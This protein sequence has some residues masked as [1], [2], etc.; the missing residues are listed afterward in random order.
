MIYDAR[1][2]WYLYKD[3]VIVA[4]RNLLDDLILVYPLLFKPHE[5]LLVLLLS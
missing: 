2:Y 3:R 1:E 5:I 4:T